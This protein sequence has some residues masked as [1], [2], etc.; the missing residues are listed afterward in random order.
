MSF[1]LEELPLFVLFLIFGGAAGVVWVAAIYLTRATDLLA[2][3]L[4]WGEALGGMLLLAIVGNLPEVA[5]VASAALQN[6]FGI[7]IGNILG[8][9]AIQTII[10]AFLDLKAV[11]PGAPL[12]K[13]THSLGLVLGGLTVVLVLA[14]VV[15]GAQLPETLIWARMTPAVLGIALTWVAGLWLVG[16]ARKGLAWQVRDRAQEEAPAALQGTGMEAK[17]L[18]YGWLV[19][20][21]GALATLAA[22]VLLE[23]SSEAIAGRIGMSGV[24]FGAT[25]LAAVTALP[26]VSAGLAAVKLGDYDLS[27]AQIFGGN[28]FL[29][30]LFLQATLLSGQAVLPALQGV[31]LYLAGLGMLLTLVYLVGLIVRFPHRPARMGVDSLI[32]LL[33]YLLGMAGL[34]FIG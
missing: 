25:L 30:V 16:K 13:R 10:L 17:S 31:D 15:V 14:W 8:G 5:I 20:A 12:T 27:V 33:L 29:P 1:L 22:G 32:A 21:V 3:R 18:T 19:F 11:P 26:E 4:H 9:I 7:A 34:F 6:H 2:E 23:S 24:L 28:A